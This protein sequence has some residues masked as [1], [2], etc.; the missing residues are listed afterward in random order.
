[1]CTFWTNFVSKTKFCFEF[2]KW[3]VILKSTLSIILCNPREI[4]GENDWYLILGPC[5]PKKH[6]RF[7]IQGNLRSRFQKLNVTYESSHIICRHCLSI[8]NLP[9]NAL[10]S[11]SKI[12]FLLKISVIKIIEMSIFY[13][14][15]CLH[16]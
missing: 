13:G 6:T 9:K 14:M 3:I 16:L 5:L 11:P 1:M 10:N 7:A 8:F 12:R 15:I 4:D 2:R